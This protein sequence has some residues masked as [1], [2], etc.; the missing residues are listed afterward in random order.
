MYVQSQWVNMWF[1]RCT[2]VCMH[3]CETGLNTNLFKSILHREITY[4]S[5]LLQTVSLYS[6]RLENSHASWLKSLP[7]GERSQHPQRSCY[8][9]SEWTL[10]SSRKPSRR[11][12]GKWEL[13]WQMVE[14]SRIL[15]YHCILYKTVH[16]V[17][18]FSSC[19]FSEDWTLTEDVCSH[20]LETCKWK[21][22]S[23]EQNSLRESLK[24]LA[25][26]KMYMK[27]PKQTGKQ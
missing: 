15:S 1:S 16:C 5:N 14:F 18:S 19:W 27:N 17:Q 4:L 21:A 8:S 12:Y 22:P 20:S 26:N 10:I 6:E 9:E 24:G 3:T 2:S 7:P 13:R 23:S 11:I 25:K